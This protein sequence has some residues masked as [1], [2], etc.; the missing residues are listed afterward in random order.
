MNGPFL[1]SVPIRTGLELARYEHIDER[2]RQIGLSFGGRE[3]QYPAL[4]ATDVLQQAEY[5]R[6]FPHL[7]MF[8]SRLAQPEAV[9]SQHDLSSN[10]AMTEWCLSPAVCYHAYANLAGCVLREPTVI[11]AR[12]TCFRY[13]R[14]RAPGIRQVEFAMREIVLL[15][16]PEWVTTS[17]D[18]LAC[19]IESLAGEL[20]LAGVWRAAADP[21]FLSAAKGK[22]ILQ[23][24]M[25]VKR[26]YQSLD[27]SGLALA[28]V[29]RHGPFFGQRFQITAPDGE[30]V[31][32]ACVAVGLDRWWW[33]GRLPQVTEE[34]ITCS[35]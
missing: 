12:G 27:H 8:A 32:T 6:A 28:S 19:A 20:G 16:S 14:E 34:A 1:Q 13:E 22:A 9:E 21:F 23:R 18:G 17:A 15:G 7:L 35:H 29:N 31:H 10:Q 26:E 11:T 30:P 5:P 25:E 3:A 4:I 24:L 33:H 2:V